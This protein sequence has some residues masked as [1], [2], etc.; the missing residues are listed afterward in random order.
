MHA[1]QSAELTFLSFKTVLLP[2]L[3]SVKRVGD[4]Q[5]FSDN[6]L[7]LEFASA[8]SHVIL[9]PQPGYVPKVPTPPFRDLVV[10]LQALLR[11]ELLLFPVRTLR[12]Y[13]DRTHSFRT[14]D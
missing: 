9:R 12:V 5:E 6:D 4:L 1:L 7:C 8:D 10:N 2:A 13:V 3:A 14:S 11:E